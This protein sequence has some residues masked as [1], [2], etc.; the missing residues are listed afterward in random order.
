[1]SGRLIQVSDVH[2]GRENAAA[3]E[4]AMELTH[5]LKPD[6]TLVTGD[7]TQSGQPEEFEAAARWKDLTGV[8]GEVTYSGKALAAVRALGRSAAYRDRTILLWN[9]LSTPRPA[10]GGGACGKVPASF[11]AVFTGET[12]A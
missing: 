11:D 5:T 8:S 10:P 2:F 12:V 6:L 9:T 3:A 7:V 4:A 1:M